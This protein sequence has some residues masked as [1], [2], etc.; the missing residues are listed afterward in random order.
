[1]FVRISSFV[2]QVSFASLSINVSSFENTDIALL[3]FI[4]SMADKE[5]LIDD[6]AS[7]SDIMFDSLYKTP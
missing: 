6:I 1:M 7:S 4:D 3:N 5:S 2:S